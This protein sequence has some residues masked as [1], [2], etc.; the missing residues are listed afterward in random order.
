MS[1]ID[2]I[3]RSG[4]ALATNNK[5]DFT[6]DGW[7]LEVLRSHPIY[8][9]SQK[10]PPEVLDNF[11]KIFA[12]QKSGKI[13]SLDEKSVA[14]WQKTPRPS[15][16]EGGEQKDAY[17]A[18]EADLYDTFKV[19]TDNTLR[20]NYN[21]SN[22]TDNKATLITFLTFNTMQVRHRLYDEKLLRFQQEVK[23]SSSFF[24]G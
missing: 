22:R 9:G 11:H 6:K 12:M 13:V 15:L 16:L 7:Q 21:G 4:D 19:M 18:T 23:I 24:D 20:M 8:T 5:I 10:F 3:L 14:D 1:Y 2:S 17:G